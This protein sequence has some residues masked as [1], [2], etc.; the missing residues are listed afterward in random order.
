MLPVPLWVV[1]AALIVLV[2][3]SRP[4]APGGVMSVSVWTTAVCGATGADD[5]GWDGAGT[6]IEVG[7]RKDGAQAGSA[8]RVEAQPASRRKASAAG[9]ASVMAHFAIS[10]FT[11][12][13]SLA[14]A[15][16]GTR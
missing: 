11:V 15:E 2:S 16:E 3:V 8:A 10:G 5:D 4:T 6:T 9:P 14:P 1:A 12:A 7:F 13:C